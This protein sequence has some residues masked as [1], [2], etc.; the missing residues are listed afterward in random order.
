MLES[1]VINLKEL[2]AIFS[3]LKNQK[4]TLYL[5]QETYSLKEDGKVWSAEWGG[6]ALFSHGSEHSR[7][8]CI[9]LKVGAACALNLAYPDPNGRYIVTKLSIGGRRT[10]FVFNI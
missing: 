3:Y 2:R 6:Q 10:I 1:Y 4:A 9:L 8:V 7:G 5:L